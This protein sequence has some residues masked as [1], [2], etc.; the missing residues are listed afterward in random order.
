MFT[1][2]GV[3]VLA[4]L[5]DVEEKE[6]ASLFDVNVFG[7]Y[8]ITDVALASRLSFF[9]WSSIPDEELLALA[10]RGRAVRAEPEW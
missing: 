5:I 2:A 4:P 6:L 7:P 1:T 10:E 9:L 8:R 3:A